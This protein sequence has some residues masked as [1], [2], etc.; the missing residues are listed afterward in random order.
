VLAIRFALGRT[1]Q[2]ADFNGVMIEFRK[3]PFGNVLLA[4]LAFGFAGYSLWCLIQ[5]FMD[6]ERKGNSVAGLITRFFYAAVG[7]IYAGL[8]WSAIRLVTATGTVSPGDKT[9]Q[10]MTARSFAFAPFGRWLVGIAGAGFIVFCVYELRRAFVR[11]FEVVKTEGAKE[12]KDRL[13]T[14]LGQAGISA[15]AIV[16]AL[17]GSFLIQSAI[18]YDPRKVRG[19]NGALVALMRPPAG[20][21]LLPIVAFGLIAYGLYML[22]LSWRRRI[23][24]L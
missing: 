20:H 18:D 23:D 7:L 13:G 14:R 15:R 8:A 19:I 11:T 24:P 5:A 9:E 16:F 22:F 1:H 21:W 2:A 17:I 4:A 10:A 6:T 3:A 12:T